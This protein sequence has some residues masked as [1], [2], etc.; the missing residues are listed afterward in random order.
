MQTDAVK[1]HNLD[2]KT[3][4]GNLLYE[5]QQ[6][7]ELVNYNLMGAEIKQRNQEESLQDRTRNMQ[8]EINEQYN[9][10]VVVKETVKDVKKA[11]DLAI[12]MGEKIRE[13]HGEDFVQ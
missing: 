5:K 13:A 1:K 9:K 11:V 7:E 6:M 2:K 4:P 3:I 8:T 10:N 12:K